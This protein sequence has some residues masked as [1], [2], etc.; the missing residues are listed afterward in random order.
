MFAGVTS[1]PPAINLFPHQ[2]TVVPMLIDDVNPPEAAGVQLE[3]SIEYWIVFP[4]ELSC[5]TATH[6]FEPFHATARPV[7]ENP[8]DALLFQLQPSVEYLIE[9]IA[10]PA[11]S[12][13]ATHK[14]FG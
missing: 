13:A 4:L 5:P 2:A 10:P 8:P 1:A 14:L 9:P 11:S 12:P 3:P 7:T 6:L